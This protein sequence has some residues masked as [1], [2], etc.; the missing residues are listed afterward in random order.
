MKTNLLVTMKMTAAIAAALL[1][2]PVPNPARIK[3]FHLVP[4]HHNDDPC[5]DY[6]DFDDFAIA[7]EHSY[8]RRAQRVDPE[9]TL[10]EFCTSYAEM[11][12]AHFAQ[13]A[14]TRE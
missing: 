6:D 11:E 2:T 12:D 5:A 8:E 13:T 4:G 7:M 1:M 14:G 10:E 3:A 9:L